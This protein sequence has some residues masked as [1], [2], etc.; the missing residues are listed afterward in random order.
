MFNI[1]CDESCH[2]ENDRQKAMVIGSI[3]VP[4]S[5][6]KDISEDIKRIKERHGINRH[7]ETKRENMVLYI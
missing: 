4:R 2:L 7:A 1:Y 5:L 6:L 3:K